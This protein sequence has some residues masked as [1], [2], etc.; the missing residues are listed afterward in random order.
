MIARMPEN[1]VR[2]TVFLDASLHQALR[3]AAATDSVSMTRKA[4]AVIR[5]AVMPAKK[6]RA[7]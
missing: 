4:E 6:P 1:I 2:L 3:V 5:E 7:K